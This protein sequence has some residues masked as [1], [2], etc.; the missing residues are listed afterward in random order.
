MTVDEMLEDFEYSL[1]AIIDKKRAKAKQYD[2][3]GKDAFG[4]LNRDAKELG[5]TVPEVIFPYMVKHWEVL[6]SWR[7]DLCQLD[8]AH[9]RIDDVIIY[10][11]MIRT[12]LTENSEATSANISRLSTGSR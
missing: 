12:W 2:P 6:K 5:M 3:D 4:A 11:L 10:L 1:A 7:H 8:D 9:D